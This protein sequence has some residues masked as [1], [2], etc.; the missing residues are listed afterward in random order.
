MRFLR[1]FALP[2][3]IFLLVILAMLGAFMTTFSTTQHIDSAN[4]LQ[5]SR[6][7]RAARMGAEWAVATICNGGSPCATPL[8]ACPVAIPSPLGIAPDGFSV[9]VTCAM[10][11]YTEG[12]TPRYIF[13][14]TSTA[15]TGGS[16]GGLGYIERSVN[17]FVEFPS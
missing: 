17:A 7:Y 9:T 15:K 8:T 13:W 6:G 10:K 1:G 5:G 11:S 2:S 4:D 3:A 12:V 14:I 16:P